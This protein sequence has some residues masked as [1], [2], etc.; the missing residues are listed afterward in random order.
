M[1][2]DDGESDEVRCGDPAG[3][4]AVADALD[5][6]L[7]CGPV[8]RSGPAEPRFVYGL[9][10]MDETLRVNG[11]ALLTNDRDLLSQLAV[12]GKTPQLGVIVDFEVLP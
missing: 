9:G 8:T 12:K 1:A 10:G 4:S 6:V 11:R 5:M 3:A 7:V 2:A